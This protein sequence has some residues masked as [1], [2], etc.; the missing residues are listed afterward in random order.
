MLVTPYPVNN[1]PSN[2]LQRPRLN[3]S[4]S[5]YYWAYPNWFEIFDVQKGM[6]QLRFSLN[7]TIQNVETPLAIDPSGRLVFLITDAGLTVV[8]LGTAPLSIGYL[9]STLGTAGTQFQVRGSGFTAG[10]TATVAGQSRPYHV[11]R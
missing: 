9:S 2:T 10:I 3:T 6:L 7:Q 4:G 1:Y 8:D 11:H 5:L